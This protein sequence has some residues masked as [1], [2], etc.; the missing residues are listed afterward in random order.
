[1]RGRGGGRPTLASGSLG[2]ESV[3]LGESVGIGLDHRPQRRSLSVEGLDP[4][5]GRG[6]RVA[7]GIAAARGDD[8]DRRIDR[9]EERLGGGRP[10]SVVGDL[11]DLDPR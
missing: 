10:R 1:M 5:D 11:Q 8:R 9:V 2:V 4:G 3:G 6:G 7:V